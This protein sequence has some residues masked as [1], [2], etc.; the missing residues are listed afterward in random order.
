MPTRQN[1]QPRRAPA[2]ASLSSEP[3]LPRA[4]STQLAAS[5]CPA[6]SL[7]CRSTSR[8]P[9]RRCSRCLLRR[10]HLPHD[11]TAAAV[12]QYAADQCRFCGE[13]VLG[14]VG[15]WAYTE[16]GRRWRHAQH[17]LCG[18]SDA[19][20]VFPPKGI[21][22]HAPTLSALRR[23]LTAALPAPQ[24]AAAR[25]AFA[26]DVTC[27]TAARAQL[28]PLFLEPVRGRSSRPRDARSTKSKLCNKQGLLISCSRSTSGSL[29]I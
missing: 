24:A 17:V 26:C 8:R 19:L 20:Y 28:I 12:Q 18:C 21:F 10:C 3:I 14:E 5:S 15:S 22:R 27:P 23:D 11:H 16:E 2:V 9:C 7:S 4:T 13:C 1:R 25:A 6:A 29:E